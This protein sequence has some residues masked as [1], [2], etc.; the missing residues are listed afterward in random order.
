MRKRSHVSAERVI[1]KRKKGR[2]HW[3]REEPNPQIYNSHGR[4]LLRE[5]GNFFR[6]STLLLPSLSSHW[7]SS[8]SVNNKK[9]G[10]NSTVV[11]Q[12]S[13]L[14]FSI[15]HQN[16]ILHT[17]SSSTRVSLTFL[18]DYVKKQNKVLCPP[19]LI[20]IKICIFSELSYISIFKILQIYWCLSIHWKYSM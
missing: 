19:V 6:T 17:L 1:E 2:S 4:K 13:S 14:L 9:N 18:I 11:L 12:F 5:E 7:C 8:F 10:K 16:L 3:S 20:F 15:K